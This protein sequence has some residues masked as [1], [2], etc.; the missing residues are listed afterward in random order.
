[1][2]RAVWAAAFRALLQIQAGASADPPRLQGELQSDTFCT[3]SIDH[4]TSVTI[5]RADTGQAGWSQ[6]EIHRARG[7]WL[8]AHATP[9]AAQAAEALFQSALDASRRQE[10]LAWELRAAMSL[11]RLWRTSSRLHDGVALLSG[12]LQ[13]FT[14]GHTTSDSTEARGLLATMKS[15]S[16]IVRMPTR[17]R[18]QTG[19]T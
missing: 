3:F 1:M 17:R 8:L 15:D 9:G 12:V 4:L 19:R 11:A 7:E 2:P 10:A 14:E 6:P 5:L 16:Q 13:R 18:V